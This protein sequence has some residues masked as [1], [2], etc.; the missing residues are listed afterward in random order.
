[1]RAIRHQMRR[2]D[3]K[4]DSAIDLFGPRWRKSSF[5]GGGNTNCVEV[6]QSGRTIAVRDS[7]HRSGPILT[8]TESNWKTFILSMRASELTPARSR[9]PA[10]PPA[11]VSDDSF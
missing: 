11:G 5:S 8:L 7:K 9:T 4:T 6:A 2:W 3:M 1:M 10:A